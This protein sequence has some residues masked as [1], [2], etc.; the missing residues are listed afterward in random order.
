M[1]AAIAAVLI[2]ALPPLL[3][4]AEAN[5]QQIIAQQ[6][7]EEARREARRQEEEQQRLAAEA[8]AKEQQ[9]TRNVAIHK[10]KERACPISACRRAASTRH[11]RSEVQ[12]R[13]RQS[14]VTN[15]IGKGMWIRSFR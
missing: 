9:R 15:T 14:S 3:Q 11:R 8:A 5:R 1:T 6:A 2:F 10:Q 12:A 7:E 13:L 4:T